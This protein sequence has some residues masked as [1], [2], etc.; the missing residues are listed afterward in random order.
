M[1]V[2]KCRHPRDEWSSCGCS[3]YVMRRV[4]GRQEYE[5][6]GRDEREARRVERLGKATGAGGLSFREVGARWYRTV[7]PRI[8]SNTAHNYRHALE[9][10]TEVLGDVPVTR[11]SAPVVAEME[12]KLAADGFAPGTITNIR[13]VTMGVLRFAEDGRLIDEAPSM[14]RFS[15]IARP[16]GV[17]HLDP[18]A[19][20]RLLAGLEEGYRRCFTFGWLTGLRPGELLALERRD[21]HGRVLH[22]SR[23]LN[24]RTGVITDALKTERSRRIIDL[25]PRA[26]ACLHPRTDAAQGRLWGFSYSSALARWRDGLERCG[27]SPM[28]LHSLRHSN[29]SLR[30]AGGQ[31]IVYVCDQLG[32]ASANVTLRTYAHLIPR[33]DRDAAAL[34][35]TIT[36]LGGLASG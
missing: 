17:K 3:W 19:M 9:R 4:D 11:I 1:P 36:H 29:A 21:F 2:K 26:L 31:D 33:P 16:A 23:Q 28:G 34:D 6:V 20:E 8:R 14:R 18:P 15:P 12:A 25:S 10:A 32:H 22:V 5:N 30:L 7:E 24:T 13:V 27:L 35:D